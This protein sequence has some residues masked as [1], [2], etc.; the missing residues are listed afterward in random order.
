MTLDLKNGYF[1]VPDAKE[2]RKYTAFIT[3][4]GLFE[5]NFMLCR[6]TNS[7]AE[8]MRFITKLFK[9]LKR[10]NII[11]IYMD[12]ILMFSEDITSGLQRLERVLE[13]IRNYG[14]CLQLSKSSV[15]QTEK[16]L[17]SKFETMKSDRRIITYSL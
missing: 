12:D 4:H 7:P 10:Q 8:F 1:H 9:P 13:Y 15:L 17:T 11:L 6:I 3:H 14:L 5:Y 2:S 16:T